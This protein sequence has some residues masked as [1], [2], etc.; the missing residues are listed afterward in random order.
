MVQDLSSAVLSLE[1]DLQNKQYHLKT[2]KCQTQTLLAS[3][4]QKDQDLSQCLDA[5]ECVKETGEA[6][7][8]ERDRARVQLNQVEEEIS[9]I[10]HHCH[11]SIGS[12]EKVKN[13]IYS[14]QTFIRSLEDEELNIGD[15]LS[16]LED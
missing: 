5:I 8:M 6:L 2:L 14:T 4:D 16:G 10:T 15:K 11:Q 9:K 3:S 13:Q 1:K 12:N 7:R